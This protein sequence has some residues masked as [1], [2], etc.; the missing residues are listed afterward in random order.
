MEV[1][2]TIVFDILFLPKQILKQCLLKKVRYEKCVIF[3]QYLNA[4]QKWYKMEMLL[5]M[6]SNRKS[7]VICLLVRL[8][9][10]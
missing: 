1:H 10:A 8:H 6:N 3:D 5:L 7:Y 4:F 2:Q 9:F